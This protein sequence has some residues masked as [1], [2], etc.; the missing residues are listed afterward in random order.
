MVWRE[1]MSA[2]RR[3]QHRLVCFSEASTVT[4]LI[5]SAGNSRV[6]ARRRLGDP[7]IAEPAVAGLRNRAPSISSEA[8]AL[9]RKS[10]H[11][12]VMYTIVRPSGYQ[13]KSQLTADSINCNVTISSQVVRY[14]QSGSTKADA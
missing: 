5:G 13:R 10:T 14:G 6:A 7:P 8:Q 9:R 11:C 1:T 12:A 4:G 3:T 2:G